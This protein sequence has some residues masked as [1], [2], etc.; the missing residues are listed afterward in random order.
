MYDFE[1]N[2]GYWQHSIGSADGRYVWEGFL[3]Y[4]KLGKEFY[5][6]DCVG[7]SRF[8]LT[9]LKIIRLWEEVVCERYPLLLEHRAGVDLTVGKDL[10]LTNRMDLVAL[11]KIETYFLRRDKKATF[12]SL[13][14]EVSPTMESF[15]HR[16][17]DNLGSGQ[18]FR[19]VRNYILNWGQK[20]VEKKLVEVGEARRKCQILEGK[21]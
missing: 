12:P 8:I 14:E 15:S 4:Y 18:K 19:D 6:Y 17:V 9:L 13:I 7:Y 1:R 16:F 20:Q 3:K 10:L 11:A 2:V 5:K 21:L